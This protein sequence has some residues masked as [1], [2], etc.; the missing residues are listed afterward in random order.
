[1]ATIALSGTGTDKKVVLNTIDGVQKV[2]CSCCGPCSGLP[3]TVELVFSGLNRCVSDCSFPLPSGLYTLTLYE[4]AVRYPYEP[5]I[6]EYTSAYFFIQFQC[7]IGQT[8]F[9]VIAT[10]AS[11]KFFPLFY[12]NPAEENVAQE[13]VYTPE[14]LYCEGVTGCDDPYTYGGIVSFEFVR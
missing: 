10:L 11:N 5:Y 6:W 1:M 14:E 3:S 8:S 2:S 7:N 9:T 13:N 12:A 4:P